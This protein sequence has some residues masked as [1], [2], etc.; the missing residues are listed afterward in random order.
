MIDR[1]FIWQ[2]LLEAMDGLEIDD[3]VLQRVG[4]KIAI[5]KRQTEES[6]ECCVGNTDH[7]VD[8]G[9]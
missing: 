2:R 8:P 7:A 4:D 9:D 3:I 1:R 5:T 6:N